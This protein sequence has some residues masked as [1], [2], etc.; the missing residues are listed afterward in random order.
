[1]KSTVNERVRRTVPENIAFNLTLNIAVAE[2]DQ[3]IY[4]SVRVDE[5]IYSSFAVTVITPPSPSRV[6]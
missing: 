4:I 3:S 6:E 2:P 1:M 5:V